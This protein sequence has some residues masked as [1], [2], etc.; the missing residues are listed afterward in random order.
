MFLDSEQ[1]RGVQEMAKMD[2]QRIRKCKNKVISR[3]F[4]CIHLSIS[5]SL[6]YLFIDSSITVQILPLVPGR[7]PVGNHGAE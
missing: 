2:E 1:G 3:H 4:S 7:V 5:A 6:V